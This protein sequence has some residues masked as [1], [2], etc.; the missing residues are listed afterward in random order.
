MDT[1]AL[2]KRIVAA[3]EGKPT[4]VLKNANVVDV[5]TDETIHCDVALFENTIIGLGKYD[6]EQIYDCGGAF[7][8]P[9]FIDSHVH[10]ES[11]MSCPP[12]F[13]RLIVPFG[14]TSIVADPHEV[15]N[16]SGMDGIRFMKELAGDANMHIYYMFPSCV[17]CAPGEE[18]GA[19]L[20]NEDAAALFYEGSVYGLGEVM[21]W[22]AVTGCREEMVKKLALFE[23]R[24]IDGH[25]PGLSGNGLNAYIIGGPR[26]DHECS[27]F[28]EVM[29]KLRGGLK[30]QLRVGSAANRMEEIMRRLAEDKVPLQN[31]MFCTDDKHTENIMQE[32]HI[33][34][35]ARMAVRAGIP[36]AEAVKMAS[37]NA[38]RHYR[39]RRKGAVAPGYDA[40]IVLF[41]DLKDFKPRA[42]FVMGEEVQDT[43]CVK[44]H[45]PRELLHTVHYAPFTAEK[46]RLPVG[47]AAPVVEMLPGQLVTV[48]TEERVPR[49]NGFFVPNGAYAKGVSIERHH[50]T[51][52]VGVGIVKN[53]GLEAGAVATTVSHD[54][55]NIFVLGMNDADIIA[56][57][58]ELKRIGGGYVLA[59]G[60][61]IVSTIPLPVFGLLSDIPYEKL[62]E[63][64]HVFL[65]ELEKLGAKQQSDP[66]IRLSFFSLPVIPAARITTRGVVQV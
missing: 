35:I 60:G 11:S 59:N 4:F 53:F 31:F 14:T 17:P 13:A 9:G 2:K 10:I 48:L 66:L 3:K 52:H 33:N 40:D 27:T 1:L 30:I 63:Q 56:A 7:L 38:A 16:V 19:T 32:G 29:E 12:E 20:N 34:Y 37:Y 45:V 43:P 5:F 62:V 50:A 46:L 57:V 47:A 15:A 22:L 64:Q 51:G 61:K 44:R 23:Y 39:L 18:N 25:A 36:A 58:E 21:D 28:E 42:V 65:K 49:E 54:S 24:P 55:H 6:C 26:T 8:C 41:E